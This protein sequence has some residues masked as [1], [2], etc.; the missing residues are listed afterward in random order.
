VGT[1]LGGGVVMEA[2]DLF[3]SVVQILVL[4]LI[5]V[6]PRE[7]CVFQVFFWLLRFERF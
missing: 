2:V 4:L 7:G 6:T 3:T 1:V 5:D